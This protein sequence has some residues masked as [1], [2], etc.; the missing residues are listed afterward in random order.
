MPSNSTC[1]DHLCVGKRQCVKMKM[2]FKLQN[3]L[4]WP[5]YRLIMLGYVFI[6]LLCSTTWSLSL[7]EV[8]LMC[9]LM[10]LI[11]IMGSFSSPQ[12]I[13]ISFH[14]VLSFALLNQCWI[15]LPG[16]WTTLLH[17]TAI[18]IWPLSRNNTLMWYGLHL[19]LI[20]PTLQHWYSAQMFGWFSASPTA[21]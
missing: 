17:N 7:C 20:W 8:I 14:F 5:C 11:R 16:Y 13:I 6:A 12:S 18:T 15:V 1:F 19:I 3:L 2:C 9:V 10:L 21:R 4:I